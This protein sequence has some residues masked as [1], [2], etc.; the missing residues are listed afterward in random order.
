MCKLPTLTASPS[1]AASL[2]FSL[3]GTPFAVQALT[4]PLRHSVRYVDV[5][6]PR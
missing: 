6:A 4:Q 1:T 2:N 3:Q 5:K